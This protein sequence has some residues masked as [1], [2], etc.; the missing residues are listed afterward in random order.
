MKTFFTLII[1][2]SVLSLT[3]SAQVPSKPFSVYL[4]G[5][6]SMVTGPQDFKDY[7][8]IGFNLGAGVGFKAIPVI[9]IV[10]KSEYHSISKD[11]DFVS[12]FDGI[13]GGKVKILTFGADARISS[14]SLILPIKPYGFAGF[15]FANLK[16]DEIVIDPLVEIAIIIP[17]YEDQTKTYFN[18]GGGIE[19]GTGI[20]M[21][22]QAKYMIIKTDGDDINFIPVSFGIKF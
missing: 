6:L 15:G 4:N 10:L 18:L 7:H 14:P 16:Q 21:F 13:S 20:K 22:L 2:L 9:E 8:K 19:F 12:G 3:I 1:V 11:W 17:E 5:G